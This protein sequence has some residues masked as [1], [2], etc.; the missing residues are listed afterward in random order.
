MSKF[1]FL[2]LIST[3]VS[4]LAMAQ[5]SSPIP[6]EIQGA[7]I[8]CENKKEDMQVSVNTTTGRI[9]VKAVSNSSNLGFETWGD[10]WSGIHSSENYLGEVL[11]EITFNGIRM[12]STL[13][14]RMFDGKPQM[15]FEMYPVAN[16]YDYRK[17]KL[18]DC[19][20]GL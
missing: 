8:V 7:D 10:V 17:V 20:M 13:M 15:D 6:T 5:Y 1:L 18:V 14:M 12:Y 4:S 11:S 3:F 16:G 19:K 2:T 9:W